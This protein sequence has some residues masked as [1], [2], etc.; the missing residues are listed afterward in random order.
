MKVLHEFFNGQMD[1]HMLFQLGRLC[2]LA[3][4]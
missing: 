4:T 2:E 1:I 3:R